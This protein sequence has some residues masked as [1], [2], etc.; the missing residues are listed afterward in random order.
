MRS[1]RACIRDYTRCRQSDVFISRVSK[2]AKSFILP[3]FRCQGLDALGLTKKRSSLETLK[4]LWEYGGFIGIMEKWKLLL[5]FSIR[6]TYGQWKREWELFVYCLLYQCTCVVAHEPSAASFGSCHGHM[7][8]ARCQVAGITM[9]PPGFNCS[10]R[11]SGTDLGSQNHDA[12]QTHPKLLR[13]KSFSK[14]LT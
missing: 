13:N 2:V 8:I 5:L 3:T 4:L 9:R 10:S 6:V 11:A 12:H 14:K 7:Q 1:S